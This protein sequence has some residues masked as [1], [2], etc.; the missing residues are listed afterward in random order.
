VVLVPPAAVV[1]DSDSAG[2][3]ALTIN[4]SATPNSAI[5]LQRL[6]GTSFFIFPPVFGIPAGDDEVTA[7]RSRKK[8]ANSAWAM[9][10]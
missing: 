2:L 5:D 1:V 6:A 4:A 7:F 9:H 3:H 8:I 10:F